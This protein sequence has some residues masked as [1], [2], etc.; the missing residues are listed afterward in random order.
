[1]KCRPMIVV[2]DWDSLKESPHGLWTPDVHRLVKQHF[3][4]LQVGLASV[5]DMPLPGEDGV[6]ERESA[7]SRQFR[8]AY[9]VDSEDHADERDDFADGIL[10]SFISQDHIRCFREIRS[11]T[12]RGAARAFDRALNQSLYDQFPERFQLIAQATDPGT[13]LAGRRGSGK[14]S[15]I[16]Y[17]IDAYER[18]GSFTFLVVRM[19]QRLIGNSQAKEY[20]QYLLVWEIDRL[21][22]HFA[23]E[24][25]ITPEDEVLYRFAPYWRGTVGDLWPLPGDT[26][27]QLEEKRAGRNAYMLRLSELKYSPEFLPYMKASVRYVESLTNRPL[28]LVVDDIDHLES[29]TEARDICETAV[30]LRAELRRPL[31]ISVREETIPK[32]QSKPLFEGLTRMHVI[33]PSFKKVLQLRLETFTASVA[34]RQ[35]DTGRYS[36]QDLLTYVST[37]VQSVCERSTYARLLAFHYDLDTLLDMIRCLASSP[38]LPPELVLDRAANGRHI[39]WNLM[40]NSFQKYVYHNHYDQNS[41]F[42]NVYDNSRDHSGESQPDLDAGSENA[43]IRSRLLA[44]LA[45]RLSASSNESGQEMPSYSCGG[46]VDDMQSLG[47]SEEATWRALRAFAA[48]RLIR[49]GRFHNELPVDQDEVSVSTAVLFYVDSL[50]SEYRYI[51]NLIPV[52][53]IDFTFDVATLPTTPESRNLMPVDRV[54][55][56][57]ARFIGRCEAEEARY[58]RHSRAALSRI[59]GS[60]PLSRRIEQSVTQFRDRRGNW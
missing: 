36:R 33:P 29:S 41:F 60:V 3:G 13:V 6:E 2:G 45:A 56:D 57:F 7:A 59:W 27:E 54:I 34:Q 50:I 17:N 22:R 12:D 20:M 19:D 35:P 58:P 9:V 47:Y 26:P 15:K 30:G 5:P 39:G 42:L 38:F 31:I 14:T 40:L 11:W 55:L 24:A 16:R 51:E 44:V 23:E 48:H 43:L 1:M 21:V 4:A 28:V 8:E 46:I 37:I 25:S 53:P 49:T 32:L 10:S 18:R 52:T